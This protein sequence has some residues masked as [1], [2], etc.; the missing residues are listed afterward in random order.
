M[1]TSAE[2]AGDAGRTTCDAH[3]HH[4]HA[5]VAPLPIYNL[6]IYLYLSIYLSIYTYFFDIYIHAS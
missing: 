5:G 1:Y 6:S 4:R 3:Q 2:D